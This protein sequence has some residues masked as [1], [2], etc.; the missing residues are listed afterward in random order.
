MGGPLEIDLGLADGLAPERQF[1]K[2]VAKVEP[3]V[4]FTHENAL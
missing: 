1:S 4:L 2:L 3:L